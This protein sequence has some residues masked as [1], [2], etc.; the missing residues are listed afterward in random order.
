MALLAERL[1]STDGMQSSSGVLA[2]L[3]A[4]HLALF[5]LGGRYYKFSQR[6]S[7]TEYISTIARR[8][9]AK[10]PSYE[11]LG[12]LLGVQLFVKFALQANR[13]RSSWMQERKDKE[14]AEK[15]ESHT[16]SVSQTETVKID[17]VQWSHKSNPPTR[18]SVKASGEGDRANAIPLMYPDPDGLP[19]A[20]ELDLPKDVDR[21]HL[22][23]AR[24]ASRV[25]A[26]ELEAIGQSVLRCTLCMEQRE[27]EKGTSA[28]TECGHVFCWECILGWSKEKPECPLCR[29][30]L[31]PSHLLPIY[32][33]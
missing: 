15:G 31:N 17:D 29:Q 16:S 32:N 20:E 4:A 5:Y 27:P 3:S 19:T 10:P 9:G 8:P 11:V 12:F 7:G 33:F 21:K 14:L 2:Y 6:F 13:W 28:V 26:A 24:A 1:P 22:E 23:A 25:K 18:V 30:S